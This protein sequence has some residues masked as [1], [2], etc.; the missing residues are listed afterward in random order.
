[1]DA[2]RS[3]LE[4]AGVEVLYCN[5]YHP[6][7]LLPALA[8]RGISSLLVE[9]GAKTAK[10]FLQ[11]GL[12]DRIQLYQAPV[13]IGELVSTPASSTFVAEQYEQPVETDR[14]MSIDLSDVD[15]GP[16]ETISALDT[17]IE[18]AMVVEPFMLE[19]ASM[20]VADTASVGLQDAPSMADERP[21]APGLFDQ[22]NTPAPDEAGPAEAAASAIA[23][24][25]EST[26]TT[27]DQQ[28]A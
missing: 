8:T 1:M 20:T 12:V 26:D 9:G 23:H 7:I 13:V 24:Q 11:T 6:E 14:A 15:S 27:Q 10:L 16:V 25:A 3:A 18:P 21:V 28:N 5:P 22:D 4:A 19:P 2:R 17:A